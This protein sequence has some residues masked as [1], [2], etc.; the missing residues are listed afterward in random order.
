MLRRRLVGKSLL[1]ALNS[2]LKMKWFSDFVQL[3]NNKESVFLVWNMKRMIHK[4]DEHQNKQ[5]NTCISQIYTDEL[6]KQH[7]WGPFHPQIQFCINKWSLFCIVTTVMTIKHIYSATNTNRLCTC[8]FTAT[9]RLFFFLHN[10]NEKLQEA[11][12][13]DKN[14]TISYKP[15]IY[16]K[17]FGFSLDLGLRRSDQTAN[18]SDFVRFCSSIQS[19]V[20][21][22]SHD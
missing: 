8:N 5:K 1:E 17:C 4:A 19:H 7:V 14:V 9:S 16:V 6:H 21:R 20:W 13:A 22:K 2:V 3:F 18:S 15:F 11:V 10:R 12:I